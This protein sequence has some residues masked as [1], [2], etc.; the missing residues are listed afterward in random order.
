[1]ISKQHEIPIKID[2]KAL[3]QNNLTPELKITTNI[4]GTNLGKA[5]ELMLR[6]AGLTYVVK[7]GVLIIT[8]KDAAKRKPDDKEEPAQDAN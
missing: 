6:D 8:T 2:A 5:L 7:D 1:V 3:K 4:K